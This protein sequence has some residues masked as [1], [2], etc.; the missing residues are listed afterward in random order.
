MISP[1]LSLTR[2]TITEAIRYLGRYPCKRQLLK[3][4]H[5]Q[6]PT[7]W[8]AYFKWSGVNPSGPQA[9]PYEIELVQEVTSS[10]NT[11]TSLDK[12]CLSADRTHC[13][14]I[15]SLTELK[16]RRIAAE[17][18]KKVWIFSPKRA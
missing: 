17:F 5:S 11:F 6:T 12:S 18:F 1:T 14:S 13:L 15:I 8:D 16:Q 4:K 2:G 7:V 9:F 3:N 10:T